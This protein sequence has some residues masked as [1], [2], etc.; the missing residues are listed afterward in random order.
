MIN[1]KLFSMLQNA[2]GDVKVLRPGVAMN[3]Y[4]RNDPITGKVRLK[5]RL[6]GEGEEYRLDCTRYGDTRGRLYVSHRWGV[7]DKETKTRNLWLAN[8]YNEGCYTEY[9]NQVIL[10]DYVYGSYSS[11]LDDLSEASETAKP[12]IVQ[13]V[14]MPGTVWP[15][16]D[17]LKRSPNHHALQY[18]R[19]RLISP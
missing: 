19:D 9:S 17:I 18:L 11:A 6:R 16:A 15:L 8:C 12:V 4:Y 7:Y 1:A 14:E 2:Y 13:E 10:Y 5:K 3:C